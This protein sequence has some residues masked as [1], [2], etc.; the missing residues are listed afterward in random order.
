[1]SVPAEVAGASYAHPRQG[2]LLA[3]PA[4]P[5]APGSAD[6]A[7]IRERNGRP[8]GWVT[9]SRADA[10]QLPSVATPA[11]EDDKPYEVY[12]LGGSYVTVAHS[13][14]GALAAAGHAARGRMP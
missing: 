6:W 3:V 2:M 11:D 9:D 8:L 1:M 12:Q 10:G 4:G 7:V 14:R 13:L 5:G